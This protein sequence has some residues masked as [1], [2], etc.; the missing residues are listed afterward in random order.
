MVMRIG[1]FFFGFVTLLTAPISAQLTIAPE[2]EIDRY[3]QKE[4]S[5]YRWKIVTTKESLGVKT[6]VVDMVSQ[7]WLSTEQVDRPEWQHYLILSI[8][9]KITSDTGF[10]MISGGANGRDA[11]EDA[12][13]E[14]REIARA[15]GT[16][17]AELK[18]VP[19]QPLIFHNDGI[20]RTEDDLIGYT[21]AQYLETGDAT[22]LARNAM[23]K[24]A[25]RA[26]DTMT[27]VTAEVAHKHVVSK[28][29]VAGASKRGWTTWLTGAMDKRVVGIIPI[30]IDVLNTDPSMRHHFA[31]YGYWAPSIGNYVDHRIMEQFD[32]PRLKD[33]YRLVDPFSY[34]ERLAMPKLILNAVGDQFFLPDSSQYY[35]DSLVGEKNLRYVPN[36]DHGMK[37]SDALETLIAFYTLLIKNKPRPQFSWVVTSD[38]EFVVM[39]RDAPK[40]VRLWQATNPHA[41]DFRLETFGAQFKSDLL[42]AQ[43]DG[44]FIGKVAEPDKGWTAYFVELTYDVD[45]PVSL[46]LTTSVNVT[47]NTLPYGDRDPAQPASVTLRCKFASTIAGNATEK[48][49]GEFFRDELKIAN[50]QQEQHGTECYFN[51]IPKNFDAEFGRVS[52]W[53]RSQDCRGLSIQ[54]E[55][56]RTITVTDGP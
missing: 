50:L 37:N 49:A 14:I 34:R 39:P 10:L 40:E 41:R 35:W 38:G 31:A 6:V 22:W 5:V 51:W 19:N 11:P 20:P 27:A 23:V 48:V 47:P 24:S 42:T 45:A 44:S 13:L 32:H 36:T 8:P 1:L 43:H 25:V 55:S 21:W 3:V 30:V 7:R 18:M 56:G 26:M 4:D 2:T 33:L 16:V 52:E 46:K 53:L 28:F 15:T 29:V 54:L 17:V 12:S 9:N